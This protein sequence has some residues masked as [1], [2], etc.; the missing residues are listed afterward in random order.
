MFPLRRRTGDGR[1]GHAL[2]Q[3]HPDWH[4]QLF[5]IPAKAVLNAADGVVDD[6][7]RLLPG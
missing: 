3:I 7:T 2:K 4:L 6:G 1:A 5:V